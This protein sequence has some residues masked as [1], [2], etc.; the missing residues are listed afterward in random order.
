MNTKS[1]VWPNNGG[2]TEIINSLTLWNIFHHFIQIGS[3]KWHLE[4]V[5]RSY[6]PQAEERKFLIIPSNFG[7]AFKVLDV[8]QTISLN[9]CLQVR[10]LLS[11]WHSNREAWKAKRDWKAM[12]SSW[13]LVLLGR[14]G[15]AQA[16]RPPT[17][18]CNPLLEHTAQLPTGADKDRVTKPTPYPVSTHGKS[19]PQTGRR[20]PH[21]ALFTCSWVHPSPALWFEWFQQIHVET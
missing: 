19:P 10:S 1:P 9:S 2:E 20:A 21:W 12:N 4:R 3:T 16:G 15:H 18:P 6:E 17:A 11:C 13:L 8:F 5:F 7:N 14:V